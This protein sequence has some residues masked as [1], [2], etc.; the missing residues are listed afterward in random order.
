[1]STR[2]YEEVRGYLD[3]AEC[4]MPNRWR[5]EMKRVMMMVMAVAWEDGRWSCVY[6]GARW[7]CGSCRSSTFAHD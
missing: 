3:E 6:L 1:M 7:A 2:L 4:S 5:M